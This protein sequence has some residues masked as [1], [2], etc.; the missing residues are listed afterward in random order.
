MGAKLLV[1]GPRGWAYTFNLE[2]GKVAR[3]GRSKENEIALVEASVSSRHGEFSDN[4]DVWTY[5]DLDSHNGSKLNGKP[6]RGTLLNDNDV[7]TIGPFDIVFQQRGA[8][9]RQTDRGWDATRT[10]IAKH[11]EEFKS[12]AKE[13]PAAESVIRLPELLPS[14]KPAELLPE[15][16]TPISSGVKEIAAWDGNNSDV[17][18]VADRVA[19]ILGETLAVRGDRYALFG[20]ILAL[21]KEAMGADNGFLMIPEVNIK[22]WVIRAWVGDPA[23]WTEFGKKQ[24]VPLTAVLRAYKDKKIDSNALGSDEESRSASMKALN[25]SSYIAVPLLQENESKGVLYFDTRQS[26]RSFSPRDVMLLDR[27]GGYILEIERNGE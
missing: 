24:P 13:Q 16:A 4:S 21:L 9:P 19:H 7:I 3:L 10:V 20:K 14:H 18:W 12:V 5:K 23:A 17:V 26:G 1:D 8:K 11:A 22:R 27:I 25:V 6:T 15:S 2:C